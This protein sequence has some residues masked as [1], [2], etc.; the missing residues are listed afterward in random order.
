[1]LFSGGALLTAFL[2]PIDRFPLGFC[3]FLHL[4]GFPCP[5]CGF[6]RAFYAFAHG[7]FTRGVLNCPLALIIFILTILIFIYNTA[8]VI[9]G[10]FGFSA[11]GGPASG[12]QIRRGSILK[13]SSRTIM[14]LAVVS[15]LLLIGNWLYRLMMGFK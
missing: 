13:L 5:T 11:L 1:L 12:G 7:D 3:V 8:V 15:F 2:F 9:A 14:V 10:I 6:S 4:T